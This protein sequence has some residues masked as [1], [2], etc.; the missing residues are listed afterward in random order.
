M[1]DRARTGITERRRVALLAVL[2]VASAVM[3]QAPVRAID[4]QPDHLPVYSACTGAARLSAGF[5]DVVSSFAEPA[6]NCLAY[7]GIAV[8]KEPNRF[9]PNDP[10]TR[11][12]MALFLSRAAGPAGVILPAPAARGFEDIGHLAPHIQ[13]A[14]NQ[15]AA[16]GVTRGTSPTTFHPESPLDRRQMAVFLYRFLV[17]AP[18]GPGG[19][20]PSMVKPDDNVFRDLGNQPAAVVDAIR[21]MYEMGVTVGV[22]D[23]TFSP[24]ALLT[25]AQMALFITRAL[26]HTNSRPEGVSLQ[27][28]TSIISDGDTLEVQVSIRDAQF[29]PRVRTLIDMFSTPADDPFAPFSDRGTC[30]Q[31]AE[32]VFG[33][34]ACA[35]DRADLQVDQY[36]NLQF[37]LQPPRG[38]RLWAWTGSVGD[39]F[40]LSDTLLTTTDIQVLKAAS[41]L[42][43]TDDMSAT[44][45]MLM[46]GDS[47]EFEFQLVDEDGR[48]VGE[49]GHRAQITT[50]YETNGVRD[51]TVV[52][53]YRTDSLGRFTVT[54]QAADPATT[55]ADDE[56]TLDIDVMVQALTV[57]D[58][59]TLGVVGADDSDDDARVVWSDQPPAAATL[60]LRQSVEYHEL[61]ESGPGPVNVIVGILTDQYGDPVTGVDIE[62]T[63]DGDY[64]LGAAP[65]VRNTD[66]RGV[67][68]L[69][70]IW[71][72]TM[73]TPEAISAETTDGKVTAEPIVHYWAVPQDEGRSGL[74]VPILVYDV[75]ANLIVHD[76]AR[77]KL[78]RYDENDRLTIRGAPV[79]IETFEEA[80]YSGAYT[81]VTYSQYSNDPAHSN[82]FDLSNTRLYDDF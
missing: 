81:R 55:A 45:E 32:A 16:L 68:N 28:R 67:A 56:T 46:F 4:G 47:V 50:T 63:G 19:T 8:G 7:Y 33:S 53:T 41:A 51:L 80:M 60:R 59:S 26:A 15:M 65:A 37:V 75:V 49:A 57:V 62:F 58:R 1:T 20:D 27:S 21:V 2:L 74:G 70:Y 34:R 71:D 6:I 25:R 18:T 12:Q 24:G 38:I 64:G 9:A 44:A 36:G 39:R 76:P 66:S 40:L 61:A 10:I 23:T 29:R 11:L 13:D 17:L 3:V 30:L 22:T 79:R 5:F 48:A 73:S 42:S 31:G 52:R 82:R 14:I 69:R 77:P 54:Y 72:G 35:I 78:V 43:V